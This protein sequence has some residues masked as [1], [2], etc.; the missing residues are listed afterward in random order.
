M[1]LRMLPRIYAPLL[2]CLILLFLALPGPSPVLANPEHHSIAPAAPPA[3]PM[4]PGAS[5]SGTA[6]TPSAAAQNGA[7]H[8][9]IAPAAPPVPPVPPQQPAAT[10]TPPSP[11]AQDAPAQQTEAVAET[12]PAPTTTP[13]TP[14]A[15]VL[16]DQQRTEIRD[17]LKTLQN[18][19][20]R[21]EFLRN[22]E[23]LITVGA[24][25]QATHESDWLEDAT[26][27]VSHFSALILGLVAEMGK[28]PEQAW[29]LFISLSDSNLAENVGWTA[30]MASLV[31]VA[32]LAAEW[33]GQ[34]LLSRPRRVVEAQKSRHML[35]RVSWLVLRTLMDIAPIVAF[36]VVAF[37]VLA[38]ID[39]PFVVRLAAIT[40]IHANVLDRIIIAAGRAVFSPGAPR[41]RLLP[42]HDESATYCF[43]WVRRFS[44][45]II[46]G[47]FLLRAAWMLGLS[48]PAHAMMIDILVFIVA[49]MMIVFVLQVHK[50]VA[51]RLRKVG[52]FSGRLHRVR[53]RIAEFWHL[54]AIAYIIAA[55]LVW[56]MDVEGGILFIARATFLSVIAIL[57]ARL[58]S[59]GLR[60][61][62]ESVFQL[63]DDVRTQF[64]TLEM[65]ANRYLPALSQGVN[66][67]VALITLLSLMEIWGIG[68][69]EWLATPEGQSLLGR[70]IAITIMIGGT[71]I[72]WEIGEAFASNLFERNRN[73]TRMM[74]LL[75][76]FQNGFRIILVTISSLIV[77]SELGVDIAPLLAGAG[78]LGLAVGFGAQTMVKDVITGVFILMEDTLAVGDMVELGDHTGF[79]EKISVRTVHLRDIDGNIH[80]LPF[81]EVQT[82]KNMTKQFAYA[83]TD[84]AIALNENADEAMAVME[85]TAR[86]IAADPAFSA[87]ITGPY[88]MFG[89]DHIRES[90]IWLRGRFKTVPLTQWM[91]RRE[92]NRRIKIAF[93]KHGIRMPFPHQTIFFGVDKQGQ[94][95]P[96]HVVQEMAARPQEPP[97]SGPQ[98]IAVEQQAREEDGV[99]DDAQTRQAGP[100]KDKS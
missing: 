81:G 76:F 52:D 34:R 73:S 65:R 45:T 85:E 78:V 40:I 94:S 68:P 14:S 88:E 37:A 91:I 13:A 26:H 35:V 10:P 61:L 46:Y 1:L 41:L 32:A 21:T 22:L 67:L 86:E 8:H 51:R 80:S 59:I 56:A 39:L 62:F 58:L 27:A 11:A 17:L 19:T 90:G 57:I 53:N 18:E 23:T 71:F 93:D 43:L 60:R 95:R 54:F 64:P 49:G 20:T 25:A 15:P 66:I 44:H 100:E 47:Y 99:Q 92:F 69:F 38:A 30:L 97:V 31:L 42:M 28:L 79:V 5:P 55:Y 72:L 98:G 70:V 33:V 3:L 50:P 77:L 9:S 48:T 24:D 7:E 89:V 75:P 84:I 16:T 2:P 36:Y 12:P 83:V 87:S 29:E 96:V 82:I 74:T 63:N 4:V 6:G